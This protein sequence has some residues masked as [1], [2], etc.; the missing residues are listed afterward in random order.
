MD[1]PADISPTLTELSSCE[2]SASF[3]EKRIGGSA[4]AMY[5]ECD[6][7]SVALSSEASSASVRECLLEMGPL[8]RRLVSVA[9]FGGSAG[10]GLS[11][12]RDSVTVSFSGS[13]SVSLSTP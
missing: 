3:I 11:G 10:G 5:V 12:S 13:V 6:V 4:G 1:A 9:S 7:C 8:D 2:K